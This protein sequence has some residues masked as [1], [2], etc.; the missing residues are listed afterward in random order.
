MVLNKL[1]STGKSILII[2]G[3]AFAAIVA[4][5]VVSGLGTILLGWALIAV[6]L[7]VIWVIGVRL[8]RFALN[9]SPF[10]GSSGGGA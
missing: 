9:W 2:V 8:L 3:I 1:P 6:G 7:F 5:F 4:L 10:G